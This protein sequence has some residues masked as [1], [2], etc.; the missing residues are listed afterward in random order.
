MTLTEALESM[1]DK[2]DAILSVSPD[3]AT[4]LLKYPEI[5]EKEPALQEFVKRAAPQPRW[6]NRT[7]PSARKSC[8]SQ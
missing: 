5:L 8:K 1:A 4:A 7:K 2:L 3:A 6:N